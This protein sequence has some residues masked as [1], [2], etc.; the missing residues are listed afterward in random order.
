MAGRLLTA[1]KVQLAAISSAGCCTC[2]QICLQILLHK[3]TIFQIWPMHGFAFC[4]AFPCNSENYGFV[5]K[6][7]T[8][9]NI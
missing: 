1:F 3:G 8:K 2:M 5:K 7:C 4:S 6:T 9:I